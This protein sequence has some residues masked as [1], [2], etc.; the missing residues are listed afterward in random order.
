MSLWVTMRRSRRTDPQ[1]PSSSTKGLEGLAVP[2]KRHFSGFFVLATLR[3]AQ[4]VRRFVCLPQG[5]CSLLKNHRRVQ[6]LLFATH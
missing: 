5:M 6:L 4:H 1:A 3:K 2:G